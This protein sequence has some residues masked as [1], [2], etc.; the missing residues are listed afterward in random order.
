MTSFGTDLTGVMVRSPATGLVAFSGPVESA[1]PAE[2]CSEVSAAYANEV[3]GD[4]IWA[5][6]RRQYVDWEERQEVQGS[7]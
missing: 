6:G 4:G 2:N 5:Q 7:E 1:G 3:E